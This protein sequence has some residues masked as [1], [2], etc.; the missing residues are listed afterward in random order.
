MWQVI[1]TPL[2]PANIKVNVLAID[3]RGRST[4]VWL[5]DREPY[6]TFTT[7]ADAEQ[8]ITTWIAGCDDV[9]EVSRVGDSWCVWRTYTEQP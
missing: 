8:F 2:A 7:R 9:A 1:L 4:P 6:S 5:T 3:G